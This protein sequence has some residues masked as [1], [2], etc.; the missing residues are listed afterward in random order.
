MRS[1]GMGGTL[2]ES[3]S[4]LALGLWGSRPFVFCSVVVVHLAEGDL[5]P[6]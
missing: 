5:H 3:R 6:V 4:T 1:S 2:A